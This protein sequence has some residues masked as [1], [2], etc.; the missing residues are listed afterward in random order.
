MY[1]KRPMRGQRQ[2]I[3]K[4]I[5]LCRL[6]RRCSTRV[7]TPRQRSTVVSRIQV[8]RWESRKWVLVITV[9]NKYP[10]DAMVMVVVE[11]QKSKT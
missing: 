11:T 8:S 7:M 4:P 2:L 6:A 9:E 3:P 10:C 1:K 5:R